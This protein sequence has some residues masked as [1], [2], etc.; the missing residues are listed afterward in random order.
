MHYE[1]R[2]HFEEELIKAVRR[3]RY[4][5]A[6]VAIG[7]LMKAPGS[8]DDIFI[9]LLEKGPK[10]KDDIRNRGR[11]NEQIP[12]D[13]NGELQF[14]LND[15]EAK[16]QEGWIEN[17]WDDFKLQ[18]MEND[19]RID[20]EHLDLLDKVK[21]HYM[22]S[23][24]RHFLTT[25]TPGKDGPQTRLRDLMKHMKDVIAQRPEDHNSHSQI[26]SKFV[27]EGNNLNFVMSAPRHSKDSRPVPTKKDILD[28]K[29][30]YQY[31]QHHWFGASRDH[32]GE[33]KTKASKIKELK[34]AKLA[35]KAQAHKK[36]VK[37]NKDPELSEQ[38][39]ALD[40]QLSR[41][42]VDPQF[43]GFS[44]RKT[45]MSFHQNGNKVLEF[46][47][48]DRK[49]NQK[50]VENEWVTTKGGDRRRRFQHAEDH[51][52]FRPPKSA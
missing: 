28:D 27:R 47:H 8:L 38:M 25:T 12:K 45:S 9:E 18:M 29:Q 26:S 46:D 14:H 31:Y 35:L 40:S 5:D 36:G 20:D 39:R 37:L 41:P 42:T 33:A 15:A 13:N 21:E 2:A 19:P 43:S 11:W 10:S 50:N 1:N 22:T 34:D 3:D 49:A 52:G 30:P 48:A 4:R 6:F 16:K 24:D 32:D 7:A 44:H 17:N 51:Q 23:P